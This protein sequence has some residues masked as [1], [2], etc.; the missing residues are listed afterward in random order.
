MNSR[1]LL[2][3]ASFCLPLQMHAESPEFM[4]E[5]HAWEAEMARPSAAPARDLPEDVRTIL[6]LEPSE[7]DE[8]QAAALA[9]YFRG[10]KEDRVA[11]ARK[12]KGDALRKRFADAGLPYPPREIFMRAFKHEMELELWAREKDGPFRE[13]ATFTITAPSGGPGPQRRE[14][15]RQVPEGCYRIEVFNPKSRFHLSL[16]LNYPNESDRI[17]ADRERPGGEIYVHGGAVSIGCLPLG[18]PVIDEVFLAALDTRARGQ[19]EIRVHIFPAR[20]K[21]DAWK[22]LTAANPELRAFWEDLQPIHDA[23]ESTHLVPEFRV[24]ADGHYQL[25]K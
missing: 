15:D 19:S 10:L 8:A 18:D 7:R 25:S 22:N 9:E 24:A 23:F 13:V 11:V 20:M 2:L 17:L 14:G 4:Q 1:S 12:E 6:A 3:A 21:G 5:L 16:G